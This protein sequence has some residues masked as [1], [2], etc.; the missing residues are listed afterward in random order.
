[1]CRAALIN[2]NL[3]NPYFQHFLVFKYQRYLRL[4]TA[5][6]FPAIRHSS[7]SAKLGS[8]L[9]VDENRQP[10]GRP[11]LTLAVPAAC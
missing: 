9:I 5:I 10:I 11:C 3:I 8:N 1:M 7:R 2:E 4:E 6:P